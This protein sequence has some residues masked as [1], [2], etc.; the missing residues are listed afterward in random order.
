MIEE[1]LGRLRTGGFESA[2]L[3]KTIVGLINALI[4]DLDSSNKNHLS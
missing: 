2:R 4:K 3:T 1:L